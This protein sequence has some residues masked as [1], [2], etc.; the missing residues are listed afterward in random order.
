M[1]LVC[2]VH[3]FS[4]FLKDVFDLWK[5]INEWINLKC[6]RL[7]CK[8]VTKINLR[9]ALGRNTRDAS[10]WSC[11]AKTTKFVTIT[12]KMIVFYLKS[13]IRRSSPIKSHPK[14]NNVK[15]QNKRPWSFILGGG[16][17]TWCCFSIHP[18]PYP[19]KCLYHKQIGRICHNQRSTAV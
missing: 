2:D 14:M 12:H 10:L 13:L 8:S 15:I 1:N 19:P 7:A 3:M 5:K 17:C 6:K 11:W 4:F 18:H 16:G 9:L